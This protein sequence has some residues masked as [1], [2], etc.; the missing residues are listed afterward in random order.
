MIGGE[1]YNQKEGGLEDVCNKVSN[2]QPL[3]TCVRVRV[4]MF[5]RACVYVCMC[6]CA[7]LA[8]TSC[9]L[10]CLLARRMSPGGREELDGLELTKTMKKIKINFT[11]SFWY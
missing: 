2:V 9:Q 3:I 10:I 5:T 8:R 1:D 7:Y 6:A 11:S 4:H